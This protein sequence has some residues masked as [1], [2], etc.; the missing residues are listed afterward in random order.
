VNLHDHIKRSETICNYLQSIEKLQTEL[1]SKVNGLDE[2]Y[3]KM[4]DNTD[5]TRFLEIFQVILF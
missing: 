3:S 5:Q 1:D 4:T 2:L